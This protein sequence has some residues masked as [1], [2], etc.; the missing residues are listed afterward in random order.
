[1]QSISKPLFKDLES[2]Y[3]QGFIESARALNQ[4]IDNKDKKF[5]ELEEPMYF[6]GN[7]DAPTV[8]VMLNPG[9][10]K[11]TLT[12][13]K[14]DY[15]SIDDLFSK[16]YNHL[17]DYGKTSP[18]DN[19][20]LKQAAFLSKFEDSGIDIPNFIDEKSIEHRQIANKNVLTQKLQLELIPYGSRTFTG[21]FDTKSMSIKN[22]DLIAE[23]LVRTLDSIV[24]VPR[25][26]V[27]FGSKQ[28][29]H[30][31]WAANKTGLKNI[32][33]AEP[34]C[35]NLDGISN[36]V[37]FNTAI[38]EHNGKLINA[39]IP[40]AFPRRDLPYAFD[41]MRQYGEFCYLEMKNRFR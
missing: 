27:L 15:K 8:F 17:K 32:D 37:F 10:S 19:F 7:P 14:E 40:Y 4:K 6:V 9:S 20:D 11:D 24:E 28:F 34:V 2:L 38:I 35:F 39:G 41:R 18:L 36:R 3:N 1:M 31:F 23:H 33:I 30:I 12:L 13:V 22:I 21:I 5:N 16:H 26:Y 29:Y 25:K